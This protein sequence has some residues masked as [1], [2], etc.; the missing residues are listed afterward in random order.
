[1]DELKSIARDGHRDETIKAG[2][3]NNGITTLSTPSQTSLK[4]LIE[5]V[6]MRSDIHKGLQTDDPQVQ[7]SAPMALE[8][9]SPTAHGNSSSSFAADQE[10]MIEQRA[11]KVVADNKELI[12]EKAGLQKDLRELDNRLVR[13]QENNDALQEKLTAAEDQLKISTSGRVAH[14]EPLVKELESKIEHQEDFIASQEGQL[15][16]YQI[17]VETLQKTVN[18]LR[19]SYEKSQNLRDQLDEVKSERDSY[20]KKANTIDKYKQKLQASQG[21]ENEND[22]LRGELQEVRH[23]LNEADRARQ[24]VAGLNLAVEEYKR[25]LPKIEQDRHEL[26]MMKKQLKFDNATLAERLEAAKEVHEHDQETIA[27]FEDKSRDFESSRTPAIS[28]AGGL[29]TEL[30]NAQLQEERMQEATLCLRWTRL[31]FASR[32]AQLKEEIQKLKKSSHDSQAKNVML[33]QLLDDAIVKNT[34]LDK[35]FLDIYQ[36]KL[37]TESSLASVN[38]GNA[39]EG[40]APTSFL[41]RTRSLT[42]NPDSTETFRNLRDQLRSEQKRRKECVEELEER[43]RMLS[44]AQSDLSIVDKNK[45]DMLEELKKNNSSALRELQDDHRLLQKTAKYLEADLNNHHTILENALSGNRRLQELSSSNKD[46]KA[47]LDVIKTLPLDDSGK[48]SNGL[49][50]PLEKH[51]ANLV[52]TIAESKERLAQRKKDIEAKDQEITNLRNRLEQAEAENS[53]ARATTDTGATVWE[54]RDAA[55]QE[56]T[57]IKRENKLIASAFYD[58]S[59]RLQMSNVTLQRRPEPKGFLN[60]AREEVNRAAAVRSR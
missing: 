14:G 9:E 25:I 51:I 59:S 20:A 18:K 24:Q 5:D 10:L 32:N 30:E 54:E 11:G 34:E 4:D 27:S 39:I 23:Q 56:L 22:L 46:L 36:E 6:Y 26:Q 8:S 31:T 43:K 41:S 19:S 53:H 15:S 28:Q 38:E 37:L 50:A 33:Q 35:K 45:I 48:P 21:F 29:E 57:N 52:D 42:H 1:M 12:M 55:M 17:K 40:F 49:H 44:E 60:R 2:L 58:L 47:S 13:L 3:Q 7:E 16:D